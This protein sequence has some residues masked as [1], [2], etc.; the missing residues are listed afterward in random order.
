MSGLSHSKC[1]SACSAK[2]LV[3]VLVVYS[4]QP[5]GTIHVDLCGH[6]YNRFSEQARADGYPVFRIVV[7]ERN[8]ERA[9]IL[10]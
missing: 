8:Y 5:G 4:T 1:Q 9:F 2:A 10:T 7:D 3:R 6:H